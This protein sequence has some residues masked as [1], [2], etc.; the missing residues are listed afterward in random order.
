VSGGRISHKKPKEKELVMKR[1]MFILV[2]LC[3]ALTSTGFA[4]YTIDGSLSDWGVTPFVDWI[5]NPPA[6]YTQTD[7]V[8]LYGAAGYGEEYDF[9]AMYL[10]KDPTNLYIGVVGSRPFTAAYGMG[11]IGI[12]LNGDMTISTHGIVTGLEYSVQVG[13]GFVG[14]VR[15]N[16]VWSDTSLWQFA[17]GWQGSPY[18]ASGGTL[19]GSASIATQFYPG[20]ESGTYILEAAIPKNILTGYTNG[21]IGVHLSVWCG[22]DSINLRDP[23]VPPPVIPAP[24]A[25]LLGSFGVGL[26]GWLRRARGQ[27]GLR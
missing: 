27:I 20:M 3:G 9:E 5:P 14:Q 23:G 21:P 7:N 16:P 19:V 18:V 24:G 22:N 8:N 6:I 4:A 2:V 15:R 1:G 26:V 12:D 17:D 13:S 11:D 25:I 10:D